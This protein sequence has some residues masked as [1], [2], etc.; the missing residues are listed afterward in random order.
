M[1]RARPRVGGAADESQT[2]AR[3]TARHPQRC[4]A[5]TWP[6]D[7]QRRDLLPAI[8]FVF[9]RRGCEEEAKRVGT[10]LQLLTRDEEVEARK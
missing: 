5:P 6:R 2:T 8:F 4:A 1:D 9:S 10:S 7:L 3:E